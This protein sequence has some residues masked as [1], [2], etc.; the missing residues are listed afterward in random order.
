SISMTG[1]GG[2]K[3]SGLQPKGSITVSAEKASLYVL[4]AA[5]GSLSVS[6][7]VSIKVN[8]PVPK[9]TSISPSSSTNVGGN[10]FSLIINGTGFVTNSQVQWAGT[11]RATTFISNTQLSAAIL[12]EDLQK[13]GTYEVK[14]TNLTPGGGTS[15]S[16]TF[17][18]N[19][20]VP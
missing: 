13:A 17:T 16:A 14:V 4:T 9:I 8:N 12:T 18:L 19:N 11:N 7:T 6:Q 10:G 20:P 1:P 5:N 15:G 3:F 2:A